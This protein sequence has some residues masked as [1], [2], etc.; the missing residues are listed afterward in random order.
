MMHLITYLPLVAG[1][2]GIIYYGLRV[3]EWYMARRLDR[4]RDAE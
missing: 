4:D 1:G 2:T 3:Y